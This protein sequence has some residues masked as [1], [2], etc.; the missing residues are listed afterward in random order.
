MLHLSVDDVCI[1]AKRC[2]LEQKL[3]VSLQ[4]VICE[5]S[6]GSRMNNVNLCLEVV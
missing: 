1:V 6:I 2:I 4:E 3:L 5:E